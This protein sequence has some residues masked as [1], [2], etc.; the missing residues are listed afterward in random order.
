MYILDGDTFISFSS[1]G[2]YKYNGYFNTGDSFFNVYKNKFY[3][4]M[5]DYNRL[6]YTGNVYEYS[7]STCDLNNN[8]EYKK[9]FN[10]NSEYYTMATESA[11]LNLLT[12]FVYAAPK[13]SSPGKIGI[14]F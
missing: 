6:E 7:F 11:T 5:S 1:D 4:C 3:I 8:W 9:F 14:F 13:S 10:D 2:D 12:G